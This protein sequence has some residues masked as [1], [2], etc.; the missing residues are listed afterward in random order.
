MVNRSI[1]F[2]SSCASRAVK[3]CPSASN[4]ALTA[5]YSCGRKTSISR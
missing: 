2:P 1:F 3:L 4:V 5:Q